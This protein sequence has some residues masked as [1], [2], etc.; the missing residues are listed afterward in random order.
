MKEHGLKSLQMLLFC[1]LLSGCSTVVD[2]R[3]RFSVIQRFGKTCVVSPD[4]S[5]TVTV[6][7]KVGAYKAQSYNKDA[8]F[9]NHDFAPDSSYGARIDFIVSSRIGTGIRLMTEE[10]KNAMVDVDGHHKHIENQRLG[11]VD[12]WDVLYYSY[13]REYEANGKTYVYTTQAM[14]A[15][16]RIGGIIVS[17]ES[18]LSYEGPYSSAYEQTITDLLRQY[19]LK[20][21]RK[22]SANQALQHNDHDCHGPC[23]EQHAPRQP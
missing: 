14:L 15:M 9:V 4:G 21:S 8:F 23:S 22:Y 6:T 1:S 12:K 17:I 13:P 2:V 3:P 7:P 16:R 18:S 20:F 5:V 19:R 11:K 10:D